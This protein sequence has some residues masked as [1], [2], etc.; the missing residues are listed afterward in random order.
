[1]ISLKELNDI[2]DNNTV[3]ATV[4]LFT[5]QGVT[6]NHIVVDV[7]GEPK[8][9]DCDDTRIYQQEI[10]VTHMTKNSLPNWHLVRANFSKFMKE[11]FMYTVARNYDQ[12]EEYYLDY[13]TVYRVISEYNV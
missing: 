7:L 12:E 1:M 5:R 3:G 10:Q 8:I 2:L 4:S 11:N 6:E 9:I 13:Y